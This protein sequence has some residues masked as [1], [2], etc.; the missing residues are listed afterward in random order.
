MTS[1]APDL[2][3]PR[4]RFDRRLWQQFVEVAQPYFYPPEPGSSLRFFGLLATQLIFVISSAFFVAVGLTLLGQVTFPVF[5]TELAA[6]LVENVNA[7][8]NS[9]VLY[10]ATGGL[11]VS[12]VIFGLFRNKLRGRWRQWFVLGLLLFLAFVVSGLN[13]ILSYVFRF[14]DNALN[15]RD[16][17]VFWQFL[18]VYGITLIVAIPILIGYRYIRRKL[19]LFWREWLT[20]TYLKEYFQDRSYYELDSNAA[21]TEIDNPDQR[22]TEDVRAFT[23]TILDILLDILNSILDLVAFTGILLSISRQL[24]LGLVGYVTIGTLVALVIGTRLIK[25]N[26]DQLMLEGN[27]RYGMVHVR[28]NAES[29]AFY[30]GEDLE[31]KQVGERLMDAIRNYDLLIIWLAFLDI[32]QYAYNYFARLVPYVIIAPLYFAEQ[33]DFGT[34]GQSIFAFQMVLGALSLIPARIQDLSAFAASIERL[35]RLFEH[36]KFKTEG[37]RGEAPEKIQT[38]LAPHFHLRQVTLRTPNAERILFENLSLQLQPQETLLIIGASGCGKSSLMRAIAGLWTNGSGT[39]ERPDNSEILFLPQKPYMLL[40]SLREQLIYPNLRENIDDTEITEA[41]K[42][43][44]LPDLIERMGG[45]AVERD[46]PTV[47][48]LGEQ[49]RLALARILLNQPKYVMLDEATSALDVGNER[50]FYQLLQSLNLQYIS[51]GHRPSL[52][53]YHQWVLELTEGQQWRMI[54]TSEFQHPEP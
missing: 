49:Q 50:Q 8:L 35:G 3:R 26:F 36:F 37:T 33:V 7:L 51:V 43:V 17:N 53:D 54:S 21:N 27:F 42:M 15:A 38:Y 19:A 10:V 13:V 44:N 24:T 30:R 12:G 1:A 40:G 47:L 34:I 29:I 52:L 45:L 25:I 16:P 31:K 28:D 5:F 18:G 9:P 48:S 23:V 32:F 22:I 39:I 14:I 4:F 6:G 11:L 46:W 2:S 41:L 20:E